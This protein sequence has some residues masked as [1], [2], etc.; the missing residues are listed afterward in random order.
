MSEETKE[1][2]KDAGLRLLDHV[3]KV[4]GICGFALFLFF[5]GIFGGI[6]GIIV[7]IIFLWFA[8]G[9]IG[10]VLCHVFSALC[11]VYLGH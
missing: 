10:V 6:L 5:R 3:L 7:G 9:F 2:L 11:H 1:K 4:V 8:L